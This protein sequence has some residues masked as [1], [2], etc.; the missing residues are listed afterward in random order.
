MMYNSV[1]SIILALL[2]ASSFPPV[3]RWAG[4][5]G[6]EPTPY[7]EW[8][9]TIATTPIWETTRVLTTTGGSDR[10]AVIVEARLIEPLSEQLDS[11]IA[12]IVHDG[13]TATLISAEG[14][15]PESLR[16]L[17]QAE[18]DSGLVNAVLV[19]NL[20]VA[21]FQMINDFNNSGANDGYEEFPCDLYFMDLDGV[22][23]DT[24]ERLP[25]R[26]SLVPGVDGIYDVHSGDVAPEI[27][28]SR[29]WVHRISGGDSLLR[30]VLERGHA[31]RRGILPSSGR[32]LTYIDDDWEYW[33][34][35]WDYAHGMLHADR[36]GIWNP[37]TTR[38]TDYRQ[39]IR[40]L[41]F[42]SVLLC[43]HSWPGGHQFSFARRD[44]HDTYYANWIP[45]DNPP[46]RFYNLFAC[47]N[48]RFTEWN[49]CAGRYVF[50]N[51]H[52]LGSIGSTKTG[53]ML[54]FQDWYLPLALGASYGEAFRD[55]FAGRAA[56][57]FTPSERS[58]FYGMVLIGDGTLKPRL[59]SPVLADEEA[60]PAQTTMRTLYRS[61]EIAPLVRE[62]R[63]YNALG[64]R[65]EAT[66]ITP[67]IYYLDSGGGAPFRRI[68]V[69]R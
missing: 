61:R 34:P 22:W 29:M 41:P 38:A 21:W 52:G 51:E 69:T 11:M 1:M 10:V 32:A 15:S 66:P 49:Y 65:A 6:S 3:T 45:G 40:D 24:L 43:A 67:G 48:A 26:D 28:I 4:P 27:G 9:N 30:P 20:P 58:W 56:N 2:I 23:L 8:L 63:I 64:R 12:G 37:E 31:W 57:G 33:A 39:R 68:V 55:W 14:I 44:S 18:L 16:A 7:Q 13:K 35:G 59:D 54:E 62:G 46:S 25:G 47:S 5:P 50:S 60:L 17:L 36:T 42:E 53:S 19:G